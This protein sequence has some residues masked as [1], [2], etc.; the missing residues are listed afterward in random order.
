MCSDLSTVQLFDIVVTLY[1][2]NMM[3]ATELDFHLKYLTPHLTMYVHN[4]K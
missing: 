1:S 2:D 4:V 3:I